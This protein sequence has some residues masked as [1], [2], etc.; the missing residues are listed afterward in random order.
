LHVRQTNLCHCAA[1]TCIYKKLWP[2]HSRDQDR[3]V[4]AALEPRTVADLCGGQQRER[5]AAAAA[6]TAATATTSQQRQQQL[7]YGLLYGF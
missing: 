2:R 1:N 4:D 5:L 3:N 7:L 6:A